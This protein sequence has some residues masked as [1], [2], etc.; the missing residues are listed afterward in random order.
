MFQIV[1][2]DEAI[3]QEEAELAAENERDAAEVDEWAN[4]AEEEGA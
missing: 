3:R 4:G 1:E 2:D